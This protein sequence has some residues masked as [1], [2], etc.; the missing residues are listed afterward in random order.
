MQEHLRDCAN[1]AASMERKERSKGRLGVPSLSLIAKQRFDRL[2][3]MAVYCGARPFALYTDPAM[4]AFLKGLN[5]AYTPPDRQTLAGPLLDD[6]YDDMKAKVDGR[7]ANYSLLN[8][9]TDESSSIQFN[10]IINLSIQTADGVFFQC[11]EPVRVQSMAS[12]HYAEWIF[13]RM[14]EAT[15][16]DLS[17]VNSLATNTCATMRKTW[18]ILQHRESLR[19]VFFVPCDSHGL[20]MLIKD[21]LGLPWCLSVHQ[22][23]SAITANFRHAPLQHEI[24]REKQLLHYNKHQA[25]LAAVITRWGSQVAVIDSVLRNKQALKD[26]AVDERAKA[27]KVVGATILDR[28][29][30]ADLEDLLDVLRPIDEVLAHSE[31][32]DSHIG[33]VT[34]RWLTIEG[35]L[36]RLR[37]I[38]ETK[39]PVAAILDDL[40]PHRFRKQVSGLHWTAFLLDPASI[41]RP[42]D[43]YTQPLVMETMTGYIPADLLAE[44]RRHFFLFR[45]RQDVFS[46]GADCW[47][48]AGDPW[49]FWQMVGYHAPGLAALAARL[50][51]TPANSVPSERAF[52]TQNLVQTKTMI[53]VDPKRLDKLT[54]IHVNRRALTREKTS[55]RTYYDLREADILCL[56]DEAIEE[57]EATRGLQHVVEDDSQGAL[58]DATSQTVERVE[59]LTS[60][61]CQADESQLTLVGCEDTFQVASALPTLAEQAREVPKHV[62]DDGELLKD[63]A[64]LPAPLRSSSRPHKRRCLD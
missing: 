10:K 55:P 24:L 1:Y 40:W 29:F 8:F 44:S 60:V 28:A 58:A 2:A 16:N 19:H 39:A 13:G 22:Q 46:P 63:A 50:F 53:R 15:C 52:S 7:L 51:K 43:G 62:E 64:A 27:N 33:L 31:G 25:L 56:E 18:R 42:L 61:E 23:A 57:L 36:R 26:Y 48:D 41:A 4:K 6:C 5:A 3:A 37:S 9:V 32:Q 59:G 11:S 30:W 38:G 47:R 49:L 21:V 12:E 35:R 54:Y 14:V 20:Q 45:Q 34:S 17:R